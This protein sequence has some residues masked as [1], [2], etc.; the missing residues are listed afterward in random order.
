MTTEQRL[1]QVER[2]LRWH[3]RLGALAIAV[4]AVVVFVGQGKSDPKVIMASRFVVVDEAGTERGVLGMT[5]HGAA[6]LLY[7]PDGQRRVELSESRRGAG[8]TLRDPGG[9]STVTLSASKDTGGWI[10]LMDKRGNPRVFLSTYDRGQVELFFM[11]RRVARLGMDK[12][13][14]PSL[15]LHDREAVLRASLGVSH[16]GSVALEF[17]DTRKEARVAFRTDRTGEPSLSLRNKAGKVIWKAPG[18]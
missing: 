18:E 12:Y 4:G 9:R 6:L 15:T 17:V 13:G 11:G 2:Q 10:R 16:D 3:K 14:T 1:T 7:H 8:M 5:E